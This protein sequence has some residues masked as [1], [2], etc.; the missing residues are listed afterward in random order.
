MCSFAGWMLWVWKGREGYVMCR[1]ETQGLK[2]H[3][4]AEGRLF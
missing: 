4:G 2:H 1:A 3:A